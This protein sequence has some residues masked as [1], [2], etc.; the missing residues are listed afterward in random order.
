MAR[1]SW[2]NLGVLIG[3]FLAE[4]FRPREI[5]RF[6]GF[7]IRFR[8]LFL[9]SSA[10][11]SEIP[12]ISDANIS[13]TCSFCSFLMTR[14]RLGTKENS[15]MAVEARSFELFWGVYWI[16]LV[17]CQRYDEYAMYGMICLVDHIFPVWF[18]GKKLWRLQHTEMK[19]TLNYSVKTKILY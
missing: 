17:R 8:F 18:A 7:Q 13:V 10:F 4:E 2:I 9:D 6:F 3:P 11:A 15:N 5:L 14:K 16:I 1:Y 12:R 19:T